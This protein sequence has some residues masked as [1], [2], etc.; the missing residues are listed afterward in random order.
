MDSNDV[1]RQWA[2]RS[3]AYSPR[4]YAHHGPN[5]TSE[6]LRETL[7]RFVDRDAS[8]LE[9]GCSS[10]R[11]LWH[12]QEH[13]FENLAGIEV[14][15][16][17]FDVMDETYP[18]LAEGG[19]FYADAIENVVPEFEDNQFDVV[20]SVETLQHLHPD[21]EWLFDE[22]TRVTGAVLVTA[23]NEG[24]EDDRARANDPEVNYVNDD[25]PLYY[26]DWNTIFTER[27]FE[28]VD[29]RAGQRN[30]VRTFRAPSN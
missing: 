22:L 8:V 29:A 7:D 1:L 20:Y 16:E 18:E 30:T 23:E 24:G 19:E 2:D 28:E 27:G 3:G 6:A 25:F 14:N 26:R 12:L 9:L 15:D 10:G 17:A 21:A 13:G 5:R 4:Y 11:H